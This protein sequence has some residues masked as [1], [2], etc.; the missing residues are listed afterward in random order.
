[1]KASISRCAQ[2]LAGFNA[3]CVEDERL[4]DCIRQT[5]PNSNLLYVVDTRPKVRRKLSSITFY[6]SF[7]SIQ[8]NAIVNKAQGKG[9]ENEI[10]YENIKF[11]FFGIENIHVMRGSL[12][13]LIDGSL[14]ITFFLA[15][16]IFLC[17]V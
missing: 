5:N 16:L 4:L 8:L 7:S 17:D 12:Q 2:P 15:K 6:K 3:R 1:M 14:G 9:Y 10:Y 11:H 13:K